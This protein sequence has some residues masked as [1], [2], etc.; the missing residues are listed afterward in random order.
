[1]TNEVRAHLVQPAPDVRAARIT[2]LINTLRLHSTR[3]L[4]DPDKCQCGA[5]VVDESL[6]EHAAEQA[7]IALPEAMGVEVPAA[8]ELVD[9]ALDE[10]LEDPGDDTDRVEFWYPHVTRMHKQVYAPLITA[11]ATEVRTVGLAWETLSAHYADMVAEHSGTQAALRNERD[12]AVVELRQRNRDYGRASATIHQL[13]AEASWQ[14]DQRFAEANKRGAAVADLVATQRQVE[15]QQ[16]TIRRL[17]DE[18][19]ELGGTVDDAELL[20]SGTAPAATPAVSIQ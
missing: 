5:V 12:R 6:H 4:I 16:D 19:R 11:L 15:R 7:L 20:G 1:M 14:R 10:L 3:Q 13:R 2:K 17:L 9:Q 8:A 18:V